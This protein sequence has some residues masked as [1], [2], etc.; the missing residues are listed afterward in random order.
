MPYVN[1]KVEEFVN[2]EM[3]RKDLELALSNLSAFEDY[4][5]EASKETELGVNFIKAYL[6]LES[7]GNHDA[8]SKKGATGLGGLMESAAK[9]VGL[10][11]TR[12]IDERFDPKSII[13]SA[14]YM[15]KYIDYFDDVILGLVA[16]NWGPTRVYDNLDS[17]KK[18][19]DLI[20][21]R[22]IS[23]ESRYYVVHVLARLKIFSDHD[24]YNLNFERKP[25]FSSMTNHE[26]ITDKDISIK[27]LAKIHKVGEEAL[28]RINPSLIAEIIPKGTVVKIPHKT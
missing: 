23:L 19:D 16:Y 3:W 18:C 14:R 26:H 9:E 11:K 15:R 7:L 13:G 6:A 27:H 8:V 1:N 22:N 24:S 28:K 21:N 2:S 12:H 4:I 10:K 25:L 5:L 17:I 20:K